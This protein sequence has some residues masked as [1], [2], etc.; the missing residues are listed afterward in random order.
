MFC[1]FLVSHL[2]V[3]GVQHIEAQKPHDSRRQGRGCRGRLP[4]RPHC[5]ISEIRRAISGSRVQWWARSEAGGRP[6]KGIFRISR[7][8]ERPGIAI[9]QSE[10]RIPLQIREKFPRI[11]HSQREMRPTA[12]ARPS[13][14]R[15][16]ANR[17]QSHRKTLPV[18]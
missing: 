14:L 11:K 4:L 17:K 5:S 9:C 2:P 18:V 1:R 3:L 6:F 12:G 16:M 13:L 15:R 7:M 10:N 8:N